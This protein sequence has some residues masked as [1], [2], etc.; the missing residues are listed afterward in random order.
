[1]FPESDPEEILERELTPSDIRNAKISVWALAAFILILALYL[2]GCVSAPVNLPPPPAAS[3]PKLSMPPVPQKVS[4]RIDGDKLEA[5]D[6]GDMLLR[7]YVRAR[8][9]L[10]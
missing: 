3:C 7:G 10:R 4:L 9:L 2:P 1:M 8:S 5:D 6:G